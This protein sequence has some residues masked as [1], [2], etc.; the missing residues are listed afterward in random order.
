MDIEDIVWT[1]NTGYKVL[2][3]KGTV[4]GR[5]FGGT[6][7]PLRQIMGTEYFPD[8]DFFKDCIL[9]LE[10]CAP[11]G[12]ML[13]S[14]HD[15]RAL[16]AAGVFQNAAGIITGKLNAEEE[17]MWLKFMKYEAKREDIPILTNVDFVHRTPMTVL[18]MGALAEI[19]CQN[20][21]FVILEAGVV[22]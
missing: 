19:D 4:R 17:S 7:G 9:V 20:E 3:G 15:L 8:K 10:N 16:D 12:S 1:P 5:L 14:L 13:A 18:P 21:K 6:V 2:Q 11:Y 22:E